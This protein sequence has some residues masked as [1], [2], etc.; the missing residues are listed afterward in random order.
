MQEAQETEL[1]PQPIPDPNAEP[2]DPVGA[3]LDSRD[4]AGMAGA[5][6]ALTPK[7]A[8]HLHRYGLGTDPLAMGKAKVL[9]AKA[10][11][12]YDPS[13]GAG[14]MTWLD[15]N[16]QPLSR[17]RRQRATAI[18]VPE[19]IQL[20]NM[21]IERAAADFEIE[22]G[23]EPELDELADAA[24]MTVKRLDHVRKAFKRM[25]SESAFEG[26][27]ESNIGPD[28]L[29]EALSIV[30]DESDPVDRKILQLR[31][32]YG[33]TAR[34]D[35]AAEVA[36]TLNLTPV[37]LSRRSARIAAKLDELMESLER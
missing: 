32:G 20:D 14:L 27:L 17:F 9:A 15:R 25:P 13:S 2:Q 28:T 10:L 18:K 29:G 8:Q 5:V 21:A 6:N 16:M 37:Q 33:G 12:S 24:G 36:M 1:R 26:N 23:R 30:W 19:K 22:K 7:L 34:T 11:Q 31:T 35:S 3:W 4:P